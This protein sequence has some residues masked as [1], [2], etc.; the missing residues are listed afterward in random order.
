MYVSTPPSWPEVLMCLVIKQGD[1]LCALGMLV[2]EGKGDM[3]ACGDLESFVWSSSQM[4]VSRMTRHL[5]LLHL[6]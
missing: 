4:A 1:V 2:R 6:H 3:K 5:D